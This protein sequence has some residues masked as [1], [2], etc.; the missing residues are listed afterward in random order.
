[1]KGEQISS[2]PSCWKDRQTLNEMEN[3]RMREGGQIR[4]NESVWKRLKERWRIFSSFFLMQWD[5][6]IKLSICLKLQKY[7]AQGYWGSWVFMHSPLITGLHLII[8]APLMELSVQCA[9]RDAWRVKIKQDRLHFSLLTICTLW[10]PWSALE[11][12]FILFCHFQLSIVN[13]NGGRKCL[14]IMG[15]KLL[16]CSCLYFYDFIFIFHIQCHPYAHQTIEYCHIC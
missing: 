16:F 7:W 14:C 15:I 10:T 8:I 2:T 12:V 1:M 11:S 9:M 3:V 6:T 5:R 13:I 4:E